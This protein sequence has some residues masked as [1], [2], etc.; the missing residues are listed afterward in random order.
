MVDLRGLW[1]HLR[2]FGV[3]DD[4]FRVNLE[5]VASG[6]LTGAYC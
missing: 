5:C 4:I 3:Q 2:G 1:R 6:W